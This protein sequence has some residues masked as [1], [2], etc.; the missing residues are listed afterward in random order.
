MSN[1]GLINRMQHVLD[2]YEAGLL[3]SE[4]VEWALEFHMRGIEGVGLSVIDYSRDLA[5]RL[6]ASHRSDGMEDFIDTKSVSEVLFEL[7]L[8]LR[9]LPDGADS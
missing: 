6:V 7:R 1:L 5:Y 9:T 8:F 3:S 2:E 4:Q